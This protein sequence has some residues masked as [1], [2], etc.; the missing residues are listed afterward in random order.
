[1]RVIVSGSNGFVGSHVCE[2]LDKRG[3]EVVLLDIT[4]GFDLLVYSVDIF[5]ML[6]PFIIFYKFIF[7]FLEFVLFYGSANITH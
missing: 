6:F 5:F 4:N 2:L 7:K 3:V 1:M